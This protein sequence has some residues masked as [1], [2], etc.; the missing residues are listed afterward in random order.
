MSLFLAEQV[1]GRVVVLPPQHDPDTFVR[2]HGIGAL[3]KLLEQAETLPEF[4]LDRL[5]ARYGLTLDGKGRIIED[6]RPLMSA[7]ASPLQRSVWASHFA[8][9]LGVGPEVILDQSPRPAVAQMPVEPPSASS[10]K[11]VRLKPIS[12]PLKAIVTYMVLHPEHLQ[13][14]E[15]DGLADVLSDTIGEVIFLQLGILRDQQR[16]ELYPEDLLTVLPEGEERS[17]VASLLLQAPEYDKSGQVEENDMSE[18]EEIREWLKL[19]GLRR[20]SDQ[21]MA[22]INEAQKYNDFKTISELMQEKMK[23]DSELKKRP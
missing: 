16:N 4:V 11:P 13:L 8:K 15:E 19:F 10:S 6:L 14:L 20:R 23:V 5:V 1:S 3:N 22:D 17:L 2:E 12:G 18:L 21:L 7:A 9:I